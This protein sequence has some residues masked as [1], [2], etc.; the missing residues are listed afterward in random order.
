MSKTGH[1]IFP[2]LGVKFPDNN[3]HKLTKPDFARKI[4]F[5]RKSTKTVKIDIFIYSG[6]TIQILFI[7]GQNVTGLNEVLQVPPAIYICMYRNYQGHDYILRYFT[8]TY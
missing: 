7:F 2:K 5:I 8:I 1:R 4:L 6:S 3:G